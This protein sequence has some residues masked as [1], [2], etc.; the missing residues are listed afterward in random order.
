MVLVIMEAHVPPEQEETLTR[1]YAH[2]MRHRPGGVLQ[3]MLT[4]DSHDP[5]LWRILT[6]WESHEALEAH[7]RSNT[8][9][10]SAFAFHLAGLVPV[11][12]SS[13][14]IAYE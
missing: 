6:V 10:P 4:Q 11:A 9:M 8:T 14:V 2:V 12:T 13:E 7:Y 3:S 1:A 5:T